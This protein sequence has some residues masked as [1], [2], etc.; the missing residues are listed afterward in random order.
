[1][2]YGLLVV[3]V[4]SLIGYFQPED[5]NTIVLATT[6]ADG[7]RRSRVLSAFELDGDLYV[8]ANHWPRAW[9]RRAAAA[10]AVTVT[11]AGSTAP[12]RAVSLVG[13]EHERLSEAYQLPFAIRFLTGFPPRRFLKLEPRD[14]P[15]APK[16]PDDTPAPGSR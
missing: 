7:D 4:E 14:T 11:R 16:A 3:L 15:T 13:A 10:P 1:M 12:H 8:A 6:D 5:T 2:G 9:Y